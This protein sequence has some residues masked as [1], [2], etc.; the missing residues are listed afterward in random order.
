MIDYADR[1]DNTYSP[2]KPFLKWAGGKRWFVHSYAHLLPHKFNRY[3][4]PFLGSGAIFFA[5]QPSISILGD[6]NPDLIETYQ[7]IKDNW[8]LV[9]RYLKQHQSKHSLQHYYMVR[10]SHL[11]S[12]YSRAARFIYLNRTCWNGLYRVNR[13]GQFNVPI[14]TRSTVIFEDDCFDDIAEAL[15]FAQ[16]Y[17]RDF[18]DLIDMAEEGDLLFIDPPY[19]VRHNNNAF[20]KYNEKLF[21]WEDQKRLFQA[22][23][24]AKKRRVQVV[25][26]NAYHSSIIEMYKSTFSTKMVTRSSCMAAIP[27][28]RKKFEELVFY[29]E[30]SNGKRRN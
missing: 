22:L 3:I 7:A 1:I 19:T 12:P 23:K 25:G 30:V 8:K 9:V 20:I 28:A 4:E 6:S 21:S 29:A 24:R 14:G 2:I 10:S 26:T 11:R 15:Q 5:V 16:L 17:P 18:E 27:S 13:S